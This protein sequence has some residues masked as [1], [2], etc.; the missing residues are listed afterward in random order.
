MAQSF[1]KNFGLYGERVGVLH[2]VTLSSQAKAKVA[3]QLERLQRSEIMSAP[4][5]GARIVATILENDSLCQQWQQDL[6]KMS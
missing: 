6:L 2:V 1:S 5:Y 4:S 3:V